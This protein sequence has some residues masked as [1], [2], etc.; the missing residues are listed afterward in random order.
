MNQDLKINV[1]SNL[2]PC[3]CERNINGE[4]GAVCRFGGKCTFHTLPLK[5]SDFYLLNS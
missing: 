1:E 2:W 3:D 4:M 5:T